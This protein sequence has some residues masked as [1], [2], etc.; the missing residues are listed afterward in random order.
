MS[1]ERLFGSLAAV[2]PSSTPPSSTLDA[3]RLAVWREFLRTHAVVTGT[4][5]RELE[6]ERGLPLA[7]YDV[8]VQLAEAPD[9][10]LRMQQLATRV[11]FSRSGLTR[12]VDRMVDA[13]LVGRERCVDDRRGTFAVL[14]PAGQR[15]LRD[16]A[17]VH[18]RGIHEHFDRHLSDAD[19][20]GLEQ[21]LGAVLA[22]EDSSTGD[23]SNGD[24]A[25]V[26][27]DA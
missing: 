18:R 26:G 17:G 9:G 23:Y 1:R 22:V 2:P 4:L 16:A 27:H 25:P 21:A 11:L 13:G 20:H 24:Q 8:L 19:V 15:R 6:D 5:A 12:L 3:R 14:A 7:Q 10:R